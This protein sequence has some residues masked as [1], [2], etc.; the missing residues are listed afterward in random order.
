LLQQSQEK[1]L[2]SN[3]RIASQTGVLQLRQKEFFNLF[4]SILAEVRQSGIRPRV[5]QSASTVAF[6]VQQRIFAQLKDSIAIA[7]KGITT[8]AIPLDTLQFRVFNY[9]DAYYDVSGYA[10][11]DRQVLY[12]SS[13]DTMT[14]VVFRRRKRRWLWIFSRK[15]L[16][17]RVYFKNPHAH[18]YYSQ[19]IQVDR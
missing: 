18:I 6:G 2:L 7:P 12:I 4:P 15:I 17:Q 8:P 1:I 5:V 16:E 13:R 14:Q 19:T 11:G 10:S 9:R 3:G